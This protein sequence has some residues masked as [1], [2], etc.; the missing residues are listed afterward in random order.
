MFVLQAHADSTNISAPTGQIQFE[1]QGIALGCHQ[2]LIS[3][4]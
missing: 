2:R 4:R 3:A 1:A